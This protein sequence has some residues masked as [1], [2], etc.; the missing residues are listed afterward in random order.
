[1]SEPILLDS[2]AMVKPEHRGRIIVAGSHGG[3]VAGKHYAY[4]IRPKLVFFNDAGKGKNN[5]GIGGAMLGYPVMDSV[6]SVVICIFI[7]LC[8]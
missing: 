1:M 6:A 7:Q 3:L 8:I 2:I 4:P 5:A